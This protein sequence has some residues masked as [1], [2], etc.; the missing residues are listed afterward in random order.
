MLNTLVFEVC[1]DEEAQV[2]YTTENTPIQGAMAEAPTLEELSEKLSVIIPEILAIEEEA[3]QKTHEVSVFTSSRTP[4]KTPL[5]FVIK[6]LHHAY[7][8]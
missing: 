6:S 4:Q 7:A 5:P 1:W 2:W 3:K 8:G